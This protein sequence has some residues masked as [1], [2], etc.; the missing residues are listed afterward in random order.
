MK[1][2]ITVLCCL[3]MMAFTAIHAQVKEEV[4][5]DAQKVGNK[6]AEIASKAHSGV[7]DKI[8]R[9][10]T[11][12]DGQ[13]IYINKHDKYYWIDEKGKRH[14]VKATALKDKKKD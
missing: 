8:Y 4:K 11:G 9:D 7:V 6:T 5:K 1:R 12:P 2:I 10:K 14:Y 3:G 13:T